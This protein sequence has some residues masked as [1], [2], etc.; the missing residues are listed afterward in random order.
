[1]YLLT[2]LKRIFRS[3]L[4]FGEISVQDNGI[5]VL[6]FCISVL[7]EKRVLSK[8]QLLVCFRSP[9][10]GKEKILISNHS[11]LSPWICNKSFRAPLK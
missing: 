4:H 8:F 5:M 10:F 2:V 11:S 7:Q 6:I 3:I 1:M 9:F